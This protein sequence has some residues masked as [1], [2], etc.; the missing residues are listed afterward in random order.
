MTTLPRISEKRAASGKMF[1]GTFTIDR[2]KEMEKQ[3]ARDQK[4]RDRIKQMTAEQYRTHLSRQVK[5][6]RRSPRQ[7]AKDRA[8]DQFS[9]FIRLRDSDEHG[10]VKCCTCPARKHWKK[11]QAGHYVTRK[12]EATL[13]DEKCVNGQCAGCNRW[14]GGKPI[15][16]EQFLE[17]KYGAGTALAIRT[18]AVQ[19]CK[20]DLR[21]YKFI[22]DTYRLRVE[23][24]RAT[25]PSKFQ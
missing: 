10:I 24:I 23:N 15:E 25:E 7:I 16:Y 21:D 3:K 17:R 2:A 14:Q 11:M 1:R 8:W 5:I 6:K 20:R 9:L 4:S 12:K 13:Y 22:E 18:K 19:E